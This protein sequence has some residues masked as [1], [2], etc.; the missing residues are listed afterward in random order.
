[1]EKIYEDGE[2]VHVAAV[3]IYPGPSGKFYTTAAKATA[4]AN[5][6]E[7]TAAD[8]F[9]LFAKGVLVKQGDAYI[10]PIACTKAGVL[11]LPTVS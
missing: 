5:N 6:T 4:H 8:L 10:K 9:Q 3:V 11:T 7:I 2:Q 1:M